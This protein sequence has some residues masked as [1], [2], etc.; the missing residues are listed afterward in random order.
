VSDSGTPAITSVM[1]GPELRMVVQL[2]KIPSL[3]PGMTLAPRAAATTT[4]Q[5]A[6]END[7]EHS[8]TI[9][10]DSKRAE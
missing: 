6:K 4:M 7:D 5:M 3:V 10:R 2:G 8:I 1:V 9:E